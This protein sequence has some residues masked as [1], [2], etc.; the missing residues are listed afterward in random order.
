MLGNALMLPGKKDSGVAAGPDGVINGGNISL[1]TGHVGMRRFYVLTYHIGDIGSN[2]RGGVDHVATP[3]A[4][5]TRRI[6][7]FESKITNEKSG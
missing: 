6:R 5:L 7:F 1:W 3:T 2:W 4:S